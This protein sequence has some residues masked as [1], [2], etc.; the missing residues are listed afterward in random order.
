MIDGRRGTESAAPSLLPAAR[1]GGQ[2]LCRRRPVGRDIDHDE[3]LIAAESSLR[4]RELR[5]W[6]VSA[7]RLR[8][9]PIPDKPE[10]MRHLPQATCVPER[11]S[12]DLRRVT[13]GRPTRSP[14]IGVGPLRGAT[15]ADGG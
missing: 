3:M 11:R 13:P 12:V 2:A 8:L 1:Y 9:Q 5:L 6:I 4:Q 10:P 7:D 15:D 14:A